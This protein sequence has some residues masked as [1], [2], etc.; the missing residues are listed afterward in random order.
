MYEINDNQTPWW[1][2]ER[3]WKNWWSN[4]PWIIIFPIGIILM[5]IPNPISLYIGAHLVGY[6]L[7]ILVGIGIAIL[8]FALIWRVNK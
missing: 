7:M 5:L 4:Y 8:I 3:R 6:T 2:T 1:G